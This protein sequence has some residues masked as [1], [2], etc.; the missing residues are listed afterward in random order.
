MVCHDLIHFVEIAM[1]NICEV[2][3]DVL[4]DITT[5]YIYKG[6]KM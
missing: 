4:K 6:K 5:I 1:A 2:I 3:G